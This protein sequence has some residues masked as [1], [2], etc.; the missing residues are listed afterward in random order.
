MVFWRIEVAPRAV[1][2]STGEVFEGPT[3]N[4][5]SSDL[6]YF[7]DISLLTGVLR[8]PLTEAQFRVLSYEIVQG[9]RKGKID[10]PRRPYRQVLLDDAPSTPRIPR[11]DLFD[12]K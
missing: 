5:S 9:V 4:I 7:L 2:R 11:F 1:W 10:E 6:V 8:I 12:K 3:L